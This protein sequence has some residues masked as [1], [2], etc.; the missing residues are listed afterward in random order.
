MKRNLP[1]TRSRRLA[2]EA[3]QREADFRAEVETWIVGLPE[4]LERVAQLIREGKVELT[5]FVADR[6]KEIAKEET[7]KY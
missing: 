1:G 4:F 2:D 5:N 7:C 6:E 3:L